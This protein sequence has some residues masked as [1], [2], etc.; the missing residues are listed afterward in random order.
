MGC[1][2]HPERQKL[3]DNRGRERERGREGETEREKG[4][5]EKEKDTQ[6]THFC[7]THSV[8]VI[9]FINATATTVSS[10]EHTCIEMPAGTEK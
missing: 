7:L 6:H 2:K 5:E 4:D 1:R 9:F 10:L 3:L 8:R